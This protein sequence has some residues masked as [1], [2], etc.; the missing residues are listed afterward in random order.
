MVPGSRV[1]DAM[2]LLKSV[3]GGYS[4]DEHMQWFGEFEINLQ[5]RN[6]MRR[7]FRDPSQPVEISANFELSSEECQHII[8]NGT[9]SSG[10]W[11]GNE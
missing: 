4:Q 10:P 2:R 6:T 9:D 3:Y 1:F 5:D 8:D 7:M 11:H